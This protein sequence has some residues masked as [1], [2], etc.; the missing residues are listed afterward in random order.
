ME[1]KLYILQNR[2]II[3]PKIGLRKLLCIILKNTYLIMMTS[4]YYL[5]LESG[6]LPIMIIPK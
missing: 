3:P 5:I 4:M 6:K 2:L 1:K